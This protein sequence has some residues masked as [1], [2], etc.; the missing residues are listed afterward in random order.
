M[1]GANGP[2]A[3]DA[4]P[5]DGNRVKIAPMLEL[6][7]KRVLVT[8]G[9]GFLG[10]CVVARLR[11]EGCRAITVPRSRDSDLVQEAAVERLYEAARPEV[12]I[13]LAAQVGGVGANRASPGR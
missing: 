12:V 13:H 8:G 2:S 5:A 10:S 6:A 1:R 3:K 9:A 4:F 11:D 7:R